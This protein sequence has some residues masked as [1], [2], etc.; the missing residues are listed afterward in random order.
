MTVVVDV[1]AVQCWNKERSIYQIWLQLSPLSA[2]QYQNDVDGNA[3]VEITDRWLVEDGLW[4]VCTVQDVY[5][6]RDFEL[7]LLPRA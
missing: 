2:I 7:L 3:R 4:V 5:D 1:L 6:P